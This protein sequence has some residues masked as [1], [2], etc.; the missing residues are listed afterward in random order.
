MAVLMLAVVG[1]MSASAEAAV[2]IGETFA[3]GLPVVNCKGGLTI[4]MAAADGTSYTVPSP[5]GVITS[6]SFEAAAPP[7]PTYLEFNVFRPAGPDHF[8]VAGEDA[9]P[10][11]T[12]GLK[13]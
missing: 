2:Q 4:Q 10:I 6:W 1:A 11:E 13:T 9:E 3:P 5:G 12:S 8:T 7:T